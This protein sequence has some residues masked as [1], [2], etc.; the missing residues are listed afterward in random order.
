MEIMRQALSPG[1]SC[2]LLGVTPE[3]AGLSA[4]LVAID[5]NV[6]MIHANWS[7]NAPGK[8][9]I[10]GDWLNL[11]FSANAFDVAIGDGSLSVLSFPLQY[12]KFFS[13]LQQ[14]LKPGGKLLLRLFASPELSERCVDVCDAALD[15]KIGSF[16]AYKWR[17]AMAIIAETA[18]P[19]IRVAAIHETFERLLPDRQQLAAAAG[20]S[21]AD[22]ATIDVYRGSAINYS[23]PTLAQLRRTIPPSFRETGLLH[24]TYELAER[25]P[26]L[27]L[28]SAT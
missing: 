1:G 25:C 3:L 20:W 21:A 7:G 26:T 6:A 5:H 27:L 22:I 10:Q 11:P 19:N 14:V 2:L 23:F 16:H 9:A 17:L 18:N 24:G 15:G 4:N 28:E 13:E 8:H 12:E